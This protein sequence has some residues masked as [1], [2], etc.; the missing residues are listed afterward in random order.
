[1]PTLEVIDAWT[2]LDV[3]A[4]LSD[5]ERS[6]LPVHPAGDLEE[7]LRQ[8]LPENSGATTG[9]T[10]WSGRPNCCC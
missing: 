1:M 4:A 10:Q 5:A 3:R 9:C 7:E 8:L 6:A 2:D